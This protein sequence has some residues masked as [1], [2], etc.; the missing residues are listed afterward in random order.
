MRKV[1]I[2]V[3]EKQENRVNKKELSLS[4]SEYGNFQ[5]LRFH[6]L[7]AKFKVDGSWKRGEWLVTRR[8]SQFLKG[9]IQVPD[10]VLTFRNEV[11]DHGTKMVGINDLGQQPYFEQDFEYEIAPVVSEVHFDERGQGI[12]L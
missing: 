12:L 5:K 7:I 8:G 2:R 9:M 3:C 11:V 10:R 4:H 6:G 1:Y